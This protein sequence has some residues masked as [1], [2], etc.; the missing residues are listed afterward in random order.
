VAPASCPGA[1]SASRL[2]RSHLPARHPPRSPAHTCGARNA[3]PLPRGHHAARRR[4]G[5]GPVRNPVRLPPVRMDRRARLLP[6]RQARLTQVFQTWWPS[7]FLLRTRSET[8]ASR[9]PLHGFR[10]AV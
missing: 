2:G 3:D 10:T 8:P 4:Q 9:R 5:T 6:Q 1:A 7:P